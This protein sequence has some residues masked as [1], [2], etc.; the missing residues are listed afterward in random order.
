[1]PYFGYE[2]SNECPRSHVGQKKCLY[3]CFKLRG[4]SQ[5]SWHG[6]CLNTGIIKIANI[7]I[8]FRIVKTFLQLLFLFL[9]LIILLN[10]VFTGI[11]ID[12]GAYLL[13]EGIKDLISLFMWIWVGAISYGI[14]EEIGWRGYALPKLQEKYNPLTSTIILAFGWGIWHTPMFFYRLSLDIL[15]GWTYG[16]FIGAIILTFI[17]NSSGGSTFATI[18]FHISNNICW[19]FNIAEV[20]M[21]LTII[22]TILL[23]IILV[24]WKTRLA[25]KKSFIEKKFN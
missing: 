7:N 18:L 13:N 19:L 21:F 20:Q 16:L 10:L 1:M 12:L 23:I 15:F 17:Y 3:K 22:L 9:I 8:F 14:F 24:V 2:G 11:F 25:T 6:V 5:T 4:G